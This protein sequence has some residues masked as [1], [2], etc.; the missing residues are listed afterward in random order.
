VSESRLHFRMK[1]DSEPVV[2][3]LDG[4][5]VGLLMPVKSANQ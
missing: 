1:S 5:A 4:K 3:V 2:I